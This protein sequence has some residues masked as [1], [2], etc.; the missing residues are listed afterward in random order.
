MTYDL[1]LLQGLTNPVGY[2]IAINTLSNNLFGGMLMILLYFIIFLIA[3]P[4]YF[5]T[6][7]VAAGIFLGVISG[8]LL[9]AGFIPWWYLGIN[10]TFI[11]AGIF[12][13]QFAGKNY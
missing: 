9:Y 7:L 12:I 2:F 1:T 13:R 6:V 10:M 11:V 5:P 4:D 8:V 3:P